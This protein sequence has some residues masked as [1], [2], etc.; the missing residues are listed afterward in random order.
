M[1]FCGNCGASVPEGTRFCPSC[2]TPIN[3][4][5]SGDNASAPVN[6]GGYDNGGSAN[7]G[8]NNGGYN[9]NG[10]NNGGYNGGY[11]NNGYNPAPNRGGYRASI[12]RREIVTAVILS[13]VTCGI[14][15]LI[16]YINIINDLNTAA[17]TPDDKTAGTILLL[18]IITCGI[19]GWIWLYH[20][21]EK[22]DAIRQMNGEAPSSSSMIY[23]LL[24]IFGLGIVV[25]CLIQSELNK[26]A[27]DA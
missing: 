24:S 3:A 16:W 15:G 12:R 1:A 22:V 14:Y 5:G 19:Y 17:R 23:L 21:G 18:T 27:L 9:N 7:G 10:Y 11:N 4:A 8:Y 2:G 26:V 6:N 13:I 20:A 25:Y